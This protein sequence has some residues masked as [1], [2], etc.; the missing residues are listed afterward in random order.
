M[1]RHCNNSILELD[2]WAN[3]WRATEKLDTKIELWVNSWRATE[4]PDF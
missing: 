1:I 4:K 2:F 3:S